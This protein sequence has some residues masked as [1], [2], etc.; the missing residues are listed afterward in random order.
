MLNALASTV[1][2]QPL[3]HTYAELMRTRDSIRSHALAGALDQAAAMS[4]MSAEL[5]VRGCVAVPVWWG[6]LR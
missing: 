6:T 1:D 4:D 3:F 5:E 2:V